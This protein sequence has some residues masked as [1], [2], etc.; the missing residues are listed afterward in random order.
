M[1]G[2][3]LSLKG[4]G[5]TYAV[6]GKGLGRTAQKLHAVSDVSLEVER[7]QTLGLVGES[8]C[9]KSTLAKL[10]MQLEAPTEGTIH[11]DGEDLTQ[12]SGAALKARR[13]R[14]QMIFQDPFAALNPRMTARAIIAE[15]LVNYAVGTKAERE[16]K[17]QDTAAA[18]GLGPEHLTRFPH[19]LS[20]GQCQRVG[21]ARAVALSPDLIVADEAVS[22]LDV[23]IQAQILNLI[24]RLKAQMGLTL[25]FV[26]HDLS[27]VAH[28]SD[29][30]AVMYLGRIVEVGDVDSVFNAPAHP[31]TRTL[32]EATPEPTPDKR[33]T[34]AP[35][36]GELPSPLDPPSGCAFRTRC[37]FA[38]PRCSAERPLLRPFNGPRQVACHLAQKV[39]DVMDAPAHG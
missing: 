19:E 25:I 9:G 30:V 33:G 8:G 21:I 38:E 29:V 24:V 7:G 17:V 32:I 26:S 2:A 4:V 20:G 6:G 23:S 15:P 22:A 36:G 31:Y 3:Y 1:S 13:Q 14:F 28:V 27:V 35:L 10:I 39:N 11:L 18:V 16:R 12:L 37:A 34:R 5:K